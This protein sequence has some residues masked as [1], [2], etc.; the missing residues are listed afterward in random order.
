MLIADDAEMIGSVS[1]GCLEAD[2]RE[3]ALSVIQTGAPRLLRYDTGTD[4]QLPFSLGLGCSGSVEIFVQ[5]A[6]A[7]ELLE[8]ASDAT[9]LLHG[10]ESFAVCTVIGG[11][12][13][14]GRAVVI[15]TNGQLVGSTGEIGLDR[16]IAACATELFDSGSSQ[17]HHVGAHEIFFDLLNPPPSLV[18]LGAGA[19]TR[20]LARCAADV[21]FR[22]TIVDHRPAFLSTANFPPE[23]RLV[24]ARADAEIAE[25]SF[26]ARTYAV[27]KTH[28]LEHDTKWVGQL[29]ATDVPYIG[30]LGP[31]ART[32]EILR[33]LHHENDMRVFGPVGLDLGAE[34]PEQ[35][36]VSIVAELLA[37]VSARHPMH[38]RQKEAAIHGE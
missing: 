10:D 22:V 14:L 30:V 11:P 34:G 15:T 29:L 9:R 31:R 35:I 28:S 6:M 7:P 13:A 3:V 12:R 17:R 24:E 18:I 19:D 32:D 20:P 23:I 33:E 8:S 38:L 27:V 26:G 16:H 36:A 5:P 4:Y 37:Q 21:G 1:G 25:L 2:V